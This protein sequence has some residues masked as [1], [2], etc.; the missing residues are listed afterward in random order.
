MPKWCN[1]L[2]VSSL[3][4]VNVYFLSIVDQAQALA[5]SVEEGEMKEAVVCAARIEA[6]ARDGSQFEIAAAAREVIAA[7]NSETGHH[8]TVLG[9]ALMLLADSIK[10][11][12]D[13]R[14]PKAMPITPDTV[15]GNRHGNLFRLIDELASEGICGIQA[16]ARA[17]NVNWKA[18]QALSLI[19]I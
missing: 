14:A 7:L 1:Y 10:K 18:L 17:L 8:P 4:E 11:V 16:Q 6:L 5:S 13:T 15:Q 9:K 3:R 12:I 2:L 19:H